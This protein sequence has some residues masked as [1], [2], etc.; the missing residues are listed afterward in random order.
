ML[1]CACCLKHLGRNE[2][3]I[4]TNEKTQLIFKSLVI[5]YELESGVLCSKVN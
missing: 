2:G 5:L 4:Q 3:R 1:I